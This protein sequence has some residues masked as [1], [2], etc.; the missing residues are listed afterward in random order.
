MPDILVDEFGFTA[1]FCLTALL[2]FL[3][4]QR[5]PSLAELINVNVHGDCEKAA[6]LLIIAADTN[7]E[8]V[9]LCGRTGEAHACAFV[10]IGNIF[11]LGATAV[12]VI[13]RPVLSLKRAL[14]NYKPST[15]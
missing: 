13:Y 9:F 15:V 11:H 14:Q 8:T 7:P 10:N 5:K 6:I 2:R 1:T 4:T 12:T 3:K